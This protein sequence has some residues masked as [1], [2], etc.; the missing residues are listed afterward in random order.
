M[1]RYDPSMG[2]FRRFDRWAIPVAG[3]ALAA[4]AVVPFL[5]R[6]PDALA[7][8]LVIATVVLVGLGVARLLL[9]SKDATARRDAWLA[10]NAQPRLNAV[11]VTGHVVTAALILALGAGFVYS[12]YP[13]GWALVVA[14]AGLVVV[15]GLARWRSRQPAEERFERDQTELD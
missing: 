14:G 4:I 12:G 5:V 1:G 13:P 15:I 8:V 7:V 3:L 10:R 6:D 9:R 2:G 11:L